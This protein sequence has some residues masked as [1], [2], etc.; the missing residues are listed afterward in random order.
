MKL[1][2]LPPPRKKVPV[3]K[4]KLA[5][6]RFYNLPVEVT[7]K[8]SHEVTRTFPFIKEFG[9]QLSQKLHSL[10]NE[11]TN[12]KDWLGEGFRPLE[13]DMEDFLTES[14]PKLLRNSHYAVMLLILVLI[15]VCSVEK[16]DEVIVGS[17]RLSSDAAPI[18]IQP[19]QLSMVREIRVK[20]GEV[21]HKGDVIATLDPTF[22][23]A[24][25]N[26]LTTQHSSLRA[27]MLRI[28]AEI[29]HTRLE[30]DD[31]SP[32]SQL[33]MTLYRQRQGQYA[34]KL[35]DYD[36]RIQHDTLDIRSSE[37][38][39][40]SLQQQLRVAKEVEAMR[41]NL[42]QKK[43][44]SR[45]SLLDAQ[46]ARLHAEHDL[47]AAISH[48]DEV[49]H[50][51]KSAKSEKQAFMDDWRRQLLESLV[52]LRSDNASMS[53][54]LTK[55]TRLNDLV[56][57]SAPE[58]GVVLEVAKRSSGSVVQQAEPIA[59]LIPLNSDLIADIN[60][61]SSDVGYTKIGDEVV[62][63]VDAFPY[64]RHGF[65]Q[66][67]VRSISEDSQSN[68]PQ[69]QASGQSMSSAFHHS[70]ILLTNTHLKAMPKGARL[71]PGMTLTAEIKVGK[72]TIISYF[73]YPIT[74][75]ISES[76]RE[77]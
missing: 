43:I 49:R 8:L 42:L 6:E 62:I 9:L 57:L 59:T 2:D 19:M 52:K 14:P 25:K 13:P 53:D 27:E 58:D 60:I 16:V 45:L 28:E 23:Q 40:N 47:Q 54:S 64:Q 22:T 37:D 26:S 41:S 67:K 5:P 34:A 18:M 76:I 39:K 12:E 61:S 21:V 65:L 30:I 51:L 29:N 63:K 4:Y 66:G 55:A 24:D 50:S 33:Q 69:G 20:S 35:E 75:G 73:L 10:S 17:G 44:G 38:S 36:Q 15:I 31:N 71:I 7:K 32:E 74:R 48:L 46:S 70:Q 1:S 77:P 72:R 56:V 68:N 3:K 11:V